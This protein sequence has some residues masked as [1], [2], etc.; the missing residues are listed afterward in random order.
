M[1]LATISMSPS[2][3]RGHLRAYRTALKQHKQQQL[4]DLSA[5]YYQLARGRA[6]IDVF[7]AFKAAGIKD[8]GPALALCRA[9]RTQ[10]FLEKDRNG[11]AKFFGLS[12]GEI[13]PGRH[14]DFELPIGSFQWPVES[15]GNWVYKQRGRTV[16]PLIPPQHLPQG[17]LHNYHLL[18]EID[19]WEPVPPADPLLLKQITR[20]LFVVMAQ[21]NLTA[22]EQAVMRGAIR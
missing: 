19:K 3:A 11:S 14:P 16:V 10:L 1:E 13:R 8:Y 12:A 5:C 9:D 6:M 4:K 18:W 21:W 2:E 22:V 20:N 17:A 15:N 7:Q